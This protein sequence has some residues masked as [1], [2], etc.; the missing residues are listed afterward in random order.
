[1]VM[2][3]SVVVPLLNEEESLP[4]LTGWIKKVMDAHYF[5]Y[6]ILLIDDGSKD[7]SWEIIKQLSRENEHIKGIKFRRN[8]GKSAALFCGFEAAEGDVVITMDADLQDSPDE[9]PDLYRMIREEKFDMVS[10]WKKKRYDP[11]TKTLPSR[12]FNGTARAAS[13]IKLHDF[14][15]GLKAYRLAVVKSIEVFGEMHR[16]IPILAKN[17]GFSRIGEKV[18]QHQARKYG[19]TKFGIERFVNGYLDLLT[20]IFISKFAKKPMHLFGLLGTF[21][22]F[23]GFVAA[24]I[25]GAHKLTML[26]RGIRAPLV[27]DN[28]YFFLALTA[29]IIGSMLFLTGFIAELISRSSSERNKYHVE[30]KTF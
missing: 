15:C 27:T 13:G 16:Y 14:N 11:I 1:M 3:I 2:D 28:P 12:L 10:G 7:D 8:H 4:E 9:I 29:M 21:T 17:A 19:K 6:E 24:I 26:A 20:V 30:E 25:V 23:L 18:V 5:S 22:F